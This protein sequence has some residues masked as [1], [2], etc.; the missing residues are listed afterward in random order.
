[1]LDDV[2]NIRKDVLK[3][4]EVNFNLIR[5]HIVENLSKIFSNIATVAIAGYLLFL[6]IVFLSFSA[7][8]FLGS[9]LKSNELGFLC[10]AGFYCLLLV[11]FLF[12]RKQIIERPVIKTFIRLFFPKFEN[13]EKK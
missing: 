7:G 3:Y 10:I 2:D 4:I 8:F 9:V 11:L 12:L 5:L 13:D 1:M 6:I